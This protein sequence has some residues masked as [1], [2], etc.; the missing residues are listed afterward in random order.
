MA[1]AGRKVASA[2]ASAGGE[3]P[4]HPGEGFSLDPRPTSPN[5]HS[6]SLKDAEKMQLLL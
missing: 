4:G 5:F 2:S 3:G 1:T 6:T